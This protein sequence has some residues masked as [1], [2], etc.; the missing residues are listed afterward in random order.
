MTQ[1]QMHVATARF[2]LRVPWARSLKDKRQ[3]VRSLRDRL[4]ARFNAAVAEVED[5][6]NLQRAVLGVAF[7]GNDAGILRAELDKVTQL[8]VSHSEAELVDRE[9]RV[10]PFASRFMDLGRSTTEG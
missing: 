1:E 6:D 5:M 9:V 4:A 10:E 2:V 8:V 3:V 7:V